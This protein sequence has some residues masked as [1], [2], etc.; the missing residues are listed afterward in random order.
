MLRRYPSCELHALDKAFGGYGPPNVKLQKLR[1]V[2]GGEGLAK[3][4][5]ATQGMS[6]KAAIAYYAQRGLPAIGGVVLGSEAL[7]SLQQQGRADERY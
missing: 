6:K 4:V 5:R 2:L 7:A 3:L 1:E